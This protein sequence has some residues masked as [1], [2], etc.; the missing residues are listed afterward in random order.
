[1]N[2]VSIHIYFV[3]AVIKNATLRGYDTER[4]LQR[5]RIS[6]YLL[7]QEQARVS[8]EQY[9]RL[10][11]IAMREMRD[12]M[13][14]YCAKPLKLGQWSALCHWL[15]QCKTL[16]QAIKRYCLFYE[17][18]ERGLTPKLVNQGSQACIEFTAQ[19]EDEATL[20]PYA[21]EFSIFS[22]HRLICW[23]IGFAPALEVV[24]LNYPQPEHYYEYR[25]LFL[26]AHTQFGSAK[27]SIIFDRTLLEKPVV[28]TPETLAS[29]LRNPLYNI[30]VNN[31]QSTSWTQRIKDLIGKD[32]SHL[33]S[34]LD[35]A[36]TFT[37]NPKRL[38]RALNHEG[39][40]YSELKLQL[41]RD[42]AIYHLS[43]QDTS[44]EEIAFKTGFS[45]ASAFIRAF[46]KWTG[47]TPYTYRKNLL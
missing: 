30:L 25:P 11:T 47:V 15:I 34:Y 46:K 29:F 5:S 12:E 6:P 21:Y 36:N 44:V 22:F 10:Q 31:Y 39:I 28:Q 26:G 20:E 35:I 3:K 13:L 42:T 14:G 43:K 2:N 23:L 7:Q 37:I 16:G 18:L 17:I 24:T 32:L 33:P 1:M 9:A 40:S 8:A 41:R 45:E 19:P 38:R 27:C 4:L